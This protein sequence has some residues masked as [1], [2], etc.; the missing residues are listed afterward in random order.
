MKTRKCDCGTHP[1]IHTG[2]IVLMKSSERS[3][4]CEMSHPHVLMDCH[5]LVCSLGFLC[6]KHKGNSTVKDKYIGGK[7]TT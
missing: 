4:G 5:I 7:F 1:V 3:T 6:V 2:V